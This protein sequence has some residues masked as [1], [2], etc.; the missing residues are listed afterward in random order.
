[1]G[2]WSRAEESA[3]AYMKRKLK[4]EI[5]NTPQY[6]EVV[7]ERRMLR[8]LR[9]CNHDVEKATQTMLKFLQW[10]RE[11]NV[12]QIRQDIVYGGSNEPAK[13]PKGD[14]I[15]DKFPQVV[16]A[17]NA[18][19]IHGNPISIEHYSFDPKDCFKHIT[20]E[21]YLIFLIY[22]L[23]YK[24]LIL[25]QLSEEKEKEFLNKNSHIPI[26]ELHEYG[27][28]LRICMFRDIKGLS[29]DHISAESKRVITETLKIGSG[30]YAEIL[31]KSYVVNAPWVFNLLWYFIKGLLDPNTIAK[32]A[33]YG[34]DFSESI[35][36]EI[37]FENLSTKFGGGFEGGNEPFCFDTSPCGPLYYPGAPCA[38]DS[39]EST[40]TIMTSPISSEDRMSVLDVVEDNVVED[41]VE[42]ALFSANSP[43]VC[44]TPSVHSGVPSPL[45]K[46]SLMRSTSSNEQQQRAKNNDNNNDN[47]DNNND[48]DDGYDEIVK[49]DVDK[50]VASDNKTHNTQ[51]PIVVAVVGSYSGSYTGSFFTDNVK[52]PLYAACSNCPV[53]F[54]I[55][56]PLLLF[57]L[58]SQ[59]LLLLFFPL[60]SV[61]FFSLLVSIFDYV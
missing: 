44:R 36:K 37:S 20:F 48:Y 33:I 41:G 61:F 24:M 35:L 53:L 34:S 57:Y 17:A 3:L 30:N 4:S 38:L 59:S 60:S 16:L 51:H 49:E 26:T 15:L 27:Q 50:V 9:G 23:E 29:R 8:F 56:L 31:F 45:T 19:D 7:G 28:L 2:R 6:P 12:D 54:L 42:D 5:S 25:E 21:D 43:F 22:C 40:A 10:R 13:F 18:K 58:G 14:I 39:T 52:L 46:I 1:M 11:N 55:I 32:V 47:G